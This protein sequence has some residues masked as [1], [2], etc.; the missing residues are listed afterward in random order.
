MACARTSQPSRSVALVVLAWP[1]PRPMADHGVRS[2]DGG[3]RCG[4]RSV[5]SAGLSFR[6]DGEGAP[7]R[8]SARADPPVVLAQ[9]D[10]RPVADVGV[11]P[12][13]AGN[14]PGD[15]RDRPAVLRRLQPG[16]QPGQRHDAR[17][18]A[19][20][21]L[22]LLLAHPSGLALPAQPGRARH[23]GADAG[24]DP[25][26]QALVGAAEAV[27]MAAAALARPPAGTG[28]AVPARRRGGVR[29]RDRDPEHPDVVQVPRVLL[30]AAFLRCLGVHRGLRRPRGPQA[31]DHDQGAAQPQ[32]DQG[33]AD[34]PRPDTRR[35]RS[36]PG[37]SSAPRP[38]PRRSPGA[39]CW[40]SPGR[41]LCS[42]GC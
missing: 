25:A 34:R 41:A 1:G 39:A 30:P 28:V 42:S 9:P 14:D 29:V 40:P 8:S 19:A 16:S 38:P 21:V 35:S 10:P 37:T 20:R 6:S 24:A 5:R 22:P 2:A 3:V 32:H 27:R 11:R 15:V 4:G 13:A 17:Q 23:P 36:T 26:V 31:A 7:G 18:G 12:D 33:A